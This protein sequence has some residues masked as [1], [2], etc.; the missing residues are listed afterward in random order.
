MSYQ[1]GDKFPDI[2]LPIVGKE[3]KTIR[4]SDFRGEKVL[5]FMWGS[6]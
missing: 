3:N 2:N 4:I 5:L 6:W 1:I